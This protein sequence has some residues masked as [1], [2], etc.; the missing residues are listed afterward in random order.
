MQGRSA[1]K[2][3][4]VYPHF[5]LQNALRSLSGNRLRW[6]FC[7]VDVFGRRAFTRARDVAQRHPGNGR[8]VF[9]SAVRTI[10]IAGPASEERWSPSTHV[11]L[12]NALRSLI[13]L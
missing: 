2:K 13:G 1:K 7:S 5:A 10:S 9:M 12:Q 4:Y 11:A 6:L 8:V 3:W